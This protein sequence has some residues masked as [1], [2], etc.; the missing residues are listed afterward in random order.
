MQRDVPIG[1]I[2]SWSG[3]VA[4]IPS[5][6]RLCDGTQGTPD[7][8]DKFVVG[9]GDSYAVGAAGGNINHNHDFTGDPHSHWISFGEGIGMGPYRENQTDTA[10]ATGTT[11]NKD[12]RP[13][14]Y[15]LAFIMY[16]GVPS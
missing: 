8:R 7:L 10:Y 6:W 11:D 5:R 13:P 16:T 1:T 14:Y 12:G 15:A 3:S 9:A 2:Q 4:S